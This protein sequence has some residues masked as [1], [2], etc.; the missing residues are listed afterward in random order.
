[1]II[2]IADQCG[3]CGAAIGAS[4]AQLRVRSARKVLLV[5]A[6]K[7]HRPAPGGRSLSAELEHLVTRYDDIVIDTDGLDTPGRTALIAARLAIVPIHADEVDLERDYPLIARLNAARM[8]NPGL[9]VLFVAAA[10]QADP[11]AAEMLRIRT[12]VAQVMAATLFATVIHQHGAADIAALYD[13][14]FAT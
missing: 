14:V 11:S 4:L 7:T 12:Y 13:T 10:G 3:T 2:A 6:D 1:M 9:R 5:G 8:F